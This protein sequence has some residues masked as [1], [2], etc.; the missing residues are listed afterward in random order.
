MEIGEFERVIEKEKKEKAVIIPD[1][2]I[3]DF[4]EKGPEILDYEY[5]WEKEQK[6]QKLEEIKN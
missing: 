6:E 4:A 3:I 5:L 2:P 1:E